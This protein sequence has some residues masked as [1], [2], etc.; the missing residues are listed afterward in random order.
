V[1]H[2]ERAS[3]YGPR[4]EHTKTKLHDQRSTD[5]A[6]SVTEIAFHTQLLHRLP[7]DGQAGLNLPE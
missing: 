5:K 4:V 6:P 7:A 2:L 3:E 1:Q